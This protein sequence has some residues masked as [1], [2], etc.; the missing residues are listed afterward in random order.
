MKVV[1]FLL[2]DVWMIG[3]GFVYG[4]RFLRTYGNHLLGLEWMIVAT[5]G[6]N[7]LLWSLLGAR[8]DS[9]LYKLAY[10]LDA[11][12]RS[13][14][15]TLIL[16]LGLMAVTHRYKPPRAVEIGAFGLAT[17]GGLYLRQFADGAFHAGPAT[18]FLVMNLLTTVFLLYLARRLWSI[19]ATALAVSTVVVTAAATTIALTYDFFPLPFDDQDRTYFYAAALA[20]WGTQG[21]VYFRAYRAL[22]A[23]QEATTGMKAPVRRTGTTA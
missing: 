19:G 21:F 7:F 17:A 22:H 18:F 11:F 13:F 23:H 12:S 5:S 2:A 14:G 10:F 16:V 15:I 20:T 9:V 1:L 3:V 8:D 6:T 4:L